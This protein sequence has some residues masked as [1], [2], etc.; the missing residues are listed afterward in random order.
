MRKF[1]CRNGVNRSSSLSSSLEVY[2]RTIRWIGRFCVEICR[3]KFDGQ[4]GIRGE[5]IAK[6]NHRG[7]N[8]M[9]YATEENLT[10]LALKQWEA[11]HSPR[12]REIMESLVK[13]LHGFVREVDLKEEEWLMAVNC[14]VQTE[15]TS[16]EK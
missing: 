9:P 2:P 10:D 3:R 5:K 15:K 7:G 14:L 11:C 1:A 4:P 13:H 12:L 16:T 6:Y 8:P